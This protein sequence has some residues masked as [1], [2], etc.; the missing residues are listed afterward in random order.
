[1]AG[2]TVRRSY[3]R[4]REEIR[5]H[6]EDLARDLEARYGVRAQWQ[7]DTVSL[8]GNGVEGRLAIDDEAVEVKVKLGLMARMFEAPIRKVVHEH[9]ERFVD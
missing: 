1:M 2:F 8:K 9:I 4:P 3:S 5:A 7:G 6:A